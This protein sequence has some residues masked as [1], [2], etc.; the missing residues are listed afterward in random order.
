LAAAVS[1]FELS[2]GHGLTLQVMDWG[3]TWLSCQVPLD[4]PAGP[5]PLQREKPH[6]R[7]VL[8]GHAQPLDHLTEP[9]YLGG[10]VGR[11]A[12]RIAHAHYRQGGRSHQLLANEGAH[13]LHG[14]PEGFNSRRWAAQQL[15]AQELLLRLHSPDG[16]QGYPGAV[17]SELHYSVPAR[18]TVQLDF[19]SR[20][21]A[22][23]PVSLSSHAYFNL[24]GAGTSV[25]AQ[26]LQLRASRY[27]PVDAHSIPT[28]EWADV[29]GSRFDFRHAR[30]L[31]AMDATG[32][33]HCYVLDVTDAGAAAPAAELRSADGQLALRLYTDYPG[34]QLYTG[35]HLGGAHDR[36]GRHHAPQRGVALEAQ[37]LPDSPNH[38]EWPGRSCFV[39]PGQVQRHS[40]RFEFLTPQ[41]ANWR[42]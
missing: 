5:G 1:C 32:Y 31:D 23:T 41:S 35:Q 16:D 20:A 17:D 15:S 6:T 4:A 13:Q 28:S 34:L 42:A 33:D 19:C 38:P 11:F 29:A 7:E 21:S 39:E 40:I 10:V 37:Y 30:R 9:G 27:L 3:A 22:T 2:D 26:R 8:L 24:D 14:G 12:N 18:N 25:M 36:R